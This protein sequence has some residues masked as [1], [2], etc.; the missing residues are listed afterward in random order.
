MREIKAQVK[1]HI[2]VEEDLADRLHAKRG[3]PSL[4]KAIPGLVGKNTPSKSKELQVRAPANEVHPFESGVVTR[5][6]RNVPCTI[7]G[8]YPS[9]QV[10][11]GTISGGMSI[12]PNSMKGKGHEP[13]ID[14]G[15]GAETEA[16]I[17]VVG[18]ARKGV[19]AEAV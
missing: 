12:E 16:M 1:K 17:E 14:I 6:E 11:I 2:E 19:E 15:V 10:S 4:S 8:H 13:I 9:N 5:F 3:A 18:K 7:V